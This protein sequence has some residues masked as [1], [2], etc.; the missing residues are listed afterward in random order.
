MLIH[1]M[2][3]TNPFSS[4]QDR[5]AKN[6]QHTKAERTDDQ[7]VT[8]DY[9]TKTKQSYSWIQQDYMISY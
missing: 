9:P 8:T 3:L 1:F 2:V 6:T 5:P 4:F 7:N